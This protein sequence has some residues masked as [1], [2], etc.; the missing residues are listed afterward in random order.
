MEPA[1]EIGEQV[2]E[3]MADALG[4]AAQLLETRHLRR[5][6]AALLGGVEIEA[7]WGCASGLEHA[8]RSS[9]RRARVAFFIVGLPFVTRRAPG[10]G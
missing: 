4:D 10:S 1:A 6:P 8:A 7:T 5:R 9:S 3:R 2:T